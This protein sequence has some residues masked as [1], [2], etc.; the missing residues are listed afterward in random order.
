MA[1]V[2]KLRLG[3]GLAKGKQRIRMEDESRYV[4]KIKVMSYEL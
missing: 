4:I 1:R 2:C 3:L